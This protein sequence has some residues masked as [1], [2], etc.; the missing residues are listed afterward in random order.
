VLGD[1]NVFQELTERDARQVAGVVAW[2]SILQRRAGA[3]AAPA[4]TER[5]TAAQTRADGISWDDRGAA[6]L[7][8]HSAAGVLEEF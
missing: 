5:A 1:R 4:V 3:D 6:E 7:A 2:A 8:L